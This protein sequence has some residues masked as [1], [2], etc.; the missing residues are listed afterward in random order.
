[1]KNPP[2]ILRQRGDEPIE[3]GVLALFPTIP[4]GNPGQCLALRL[5]GRWV[6]VI[7]EYEIDLTDP[8]QPFTRLERAM[9]QVLANY[10][11]RLVSRL[12]PSY[13]PERE[14]RRRSTGL[15]LPP[16]PLPEVVS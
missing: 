1:M 8:V 7:P 15:S 14:Q 4:S 3:T 13:G 16:Q 11:H 12:D 10:P 9:Q 2:V 6:A 5:D